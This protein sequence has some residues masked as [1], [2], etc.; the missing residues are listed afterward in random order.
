MR[1]RRSQTS[2]R[3]TRRQYSPRQC[4]A[5]KWRRRFVSRSEQLLVCDG[6]YIGNKRWLD[7]WFHA[8]RRPPDSESQTEAFSAC[9]SLFRTMLIPQPLQSCSWCPDLPLRPQKR[10][11]AYFRPIAWRACPL[12][13]QISLGLG[14][15]RTPS[16]PLP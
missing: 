6:R 2:A 13:V 8:A 14:F 7:L 1:S 10:C 11:R 12:P 4:R 16:F 3:I 15:F 5:C 9:N